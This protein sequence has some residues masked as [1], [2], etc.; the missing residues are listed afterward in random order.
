MKSLRAA[1]DAKCRDCVVDPLAGGTRLQQIIDCTCA[2]CPLYPV[3]PQRSPSKQ[4]QM[5]AQQA[6]ESLSLS[7]EQGRIGTTPQEAMQ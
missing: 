4:K 3:R 1:I 5:Q 6:S 2:S 7:G